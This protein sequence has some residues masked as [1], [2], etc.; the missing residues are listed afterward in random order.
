MASL[1][2]ILTRDSRHRDTLDALFRAVLPIGTI[3]YENRSASEIF[4]KSRKDN[5]R[6]L[7]RSG[8]LRS[9]VQ[10][11]RKSSERSKA[12]KKN[13]AFDVMPDK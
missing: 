13:L 1:F 3:T 12:M 10:T 9:G 7:Q 5:I 11:Q 4:A 6:G 8:A 2:A